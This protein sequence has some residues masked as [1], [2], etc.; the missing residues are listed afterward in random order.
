MTI[1]L[2]ESLGL[3]VRA[4]RSARRL[5]Q[6]ELAERVERTTE[7]VSNIER[8]VTAPTIE[9]LERLGRELQVPMGE[10]FEGYDQA[11]ADRRRLRLELEV[12]QLLARLGDRD[13]EVARRQL[14]ALLER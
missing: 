9:T 2:K 10:F 3:R 12:R 1:N 13:L 11:G 7:T 6:V 4:A 5:S 8:G 14:L